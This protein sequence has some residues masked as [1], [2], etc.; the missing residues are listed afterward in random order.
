VSKGFSKGFGLKFF[1]FPIYM[2]EALFFFS[3]DSES[4]YDLSFLSYSFMLKFSYLLESIFDESI[5]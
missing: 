4:K 3:K 5:F 2:V 1:K